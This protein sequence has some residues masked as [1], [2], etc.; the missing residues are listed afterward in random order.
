[1]FPFGMK[2]KTVERVYEEIVTKK[3]SD[4]TEDKA[5]RR[6]TERTFESSPAVVTLPSRTE[7]K[8]LSHN[9]E[10]VRY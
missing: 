4:G 7:T 10:V 5:E 8:Q 6:W 9:R 2:T 3:Y 1:M